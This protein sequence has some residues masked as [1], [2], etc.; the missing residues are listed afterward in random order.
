MGLT[1][2][3]RGLSKS[4]APKYG[5]GNAALCEDGNYQS[6]C[7]EPLKNNNGEV[8]ALRLKLWA[9]GKKERG[10]YK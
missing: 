6:S 10:N 2:R 7:C 1:P 9:L 3:R 8:V 5:G 4:D